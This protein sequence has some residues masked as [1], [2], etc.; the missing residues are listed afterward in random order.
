[1]SALIERLLT[2]D[3]RSSAISKA[4]AKESLE[5]PQVL[6]EILPFLE[7][8]DKKVRA[9]V[10]EA[11]SEAS[12]VK[13]E[14]AIKY[15]SNLVKALRNQEPQ[16]RWEAILALAQVA[17][18]APEKIDP[19]IEK[20][21]EQIKEPKSM[22]VRET[23]AKLL[24]K[25]GRTDG[26]RRDKAFSALETALKQYGLGNEG[27]AII[28]ALFDLAETSELKGLKEQ[29]L[30]L[31]GPYKDHKKKKVGKIIEKMEKR[32]GYKT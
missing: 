18:V 25:W 26:M 22:I 12:K 9:A 24:G 7:H 13:P 27:A 6:V 23:T 31:V 29:A 11:I 32:F 4:L 5:K 14:L 1:M 15:T 17:E 21:I 2:S 19:Y 28:E 20:I 3:I 8:E 16:T 10:A 30:E